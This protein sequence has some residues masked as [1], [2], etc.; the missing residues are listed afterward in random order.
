MSRTNSAP[1][2]LAADI[3]GTNTRV[4]CLQGEEPVRIERRVNRDYENLEQLLG[5]IIELWQIQHDQVTDLLLALPAPVQEEV[6]QLTNIDWQVH[7]A[8]LQQDFPAA[9]I[10]LINDFQAAASGALSQPEENLI[11][12]NPG[13]FIA[14][15]CAVVTGPGTGLGMAW[16]A[17]GQD[18]P[19]ASEGGHVDFAPR[20][21]WQDA[22]TQSLRASCQQVSWECLLCGNGLTRIHAFLAPERPAQNSKEV[23]ER[24][25][26][27]EP[28]AERAIHEFWQILAA[29]CGNLALQ[30]TPH[31]GIYLA[32][33]LPSRLLTW[34]NTERFT[35]TFTENAT[36]HGVIQT[37]PLFLVKHE[38]TG[39]DGVHYLA[40]KLHKARSWVAKKTT[41]NDFTST[42]SNPKPRTN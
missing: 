11:N 5:E 13:K 2:T 30:F 38:D 39:L 20:N 24:A 23:V 29:W 10:R 7:R 41:K 35:A 33:G 9:E 17:A 37:I 36:M 8:T 16:Q 6:I 42:T 4:V 25:L 27:Q 26:Q 12:L 32:G 22:L 28:E 34:L 18:W 40:Q 3:G 14:G 21:E 1:L 15:D 19:R 31:A